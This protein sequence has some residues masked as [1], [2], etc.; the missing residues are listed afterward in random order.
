MLFSLALR[1]L[2]LNSYPAMHFTNLTVLTIPG[3]AFGKAMSSR[4]HNPEET[5]P[6]YGRF[7]TYGAYIPNRLCT[8]ITVVHFLVTLLVKLVARSEN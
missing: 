8:A 7:P 5:P 1:A 2:Y 4:K 6:K 3:E